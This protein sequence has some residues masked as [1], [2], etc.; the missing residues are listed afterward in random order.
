[1]KKILLLIVAAALSVG[2]SAKVVLPKVLGSNMVL[3]QNAEVNLWGKADINKKVVVKVGWSRDK[4]QTT[5]DEHGNW[6][7]KVPTPAGSFEKYTIAISDGEELVL[8]NVM[9]GDV[10]ITSGQSNMEMTMI[11]WWGQPVQNANEYILSAAKY[12]DKI[13]MFTVH[14][15]RSFNADKEDCVG[16]WSCAAPQSVA[17][18]SAVSYLFAYNL[19]DKVDFPIGIITSNWGGTRI[20]S[21]MPIKAL[22]EV[23]PKQTLQYQIDRYRMKPSELYCAMIAPIRKFNARGF[24]WYQGCSNLSDINHYDKMQQRLVQQWREDWGDKENKMPFYFTMIAPFDY[25]DSRAISYPLF[26]ESQIRAAANTPNCSMASTIDVGDERCIHPS[27]KAQVG[28]RLAAFAMRDLYGQGGVDVEAPLYD[29][30]RVKDNA[31]IVK[32]K[33]VGV[34]LQPGVGR[35]VKGF[36]I[37]GADKVFH[38]ATASV[39]GKTEVKVW[40]DKVAAP[41]AVRYAFRNFIPCDLKNM[42]GVPATPFRTD[43]W[44]NIK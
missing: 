32:L 10:W 38:P 6:A 3:Q 1:M 14:R 18:F 36:E 25:G 44:N 28:E 35:T 24:L 26:V 43:D 9:I 41:V 8:E 16:E 13:R 19:V 17:K 34:G 20:E 23:L 29:S 15:A 2:A 12:A 7:V 31:I 37:A 4:I 5:A 42:L 11:G 39:C 21:W 30:Y 33:N 27:A 40:S 22:E